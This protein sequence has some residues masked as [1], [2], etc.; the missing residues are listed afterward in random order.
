MLRQP[1]V[2]RPF[3]MLLEQHIRKALTMERQHIRHI[4]G[5]K[6]RKIF[7]YCLYII[8]VV[9]YLSGAKLRKIKKRC[10]TTNMAYL[11]C[12]C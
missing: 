11:K 8:I 1:I 3:Y 2:M 9:Y 12:R 6:R 7:V 4:A 5:S 10:N